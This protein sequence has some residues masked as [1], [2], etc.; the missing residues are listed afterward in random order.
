MIGLTGLS[1]SK[2]HLFEYYVLDTNKQEQVWNYFLLY[3]PGKSG[4]I[5]EPAPTRI[6]SVI[7]GTIYNSSIAYNSGETYILA[8]D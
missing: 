4:I 3:L 1:F 6:P 2:K 5:A 7:L 8:T